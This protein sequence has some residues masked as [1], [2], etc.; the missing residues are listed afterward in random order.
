MSASDELDWPVKYPWSLLPRGGSRPFV[1]D[2]GK[3][4]KNPRRGQV[5]YGFLDNDENEWVP[6]PGATL[7]SFHWD[8][9]HTDGTH[10]NIRPDGE[11]HHGPDNFP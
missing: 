4:K 7:E 11:V 10:T 9:Q 1:P 8:V 2:T 6:A 5:G 3:W